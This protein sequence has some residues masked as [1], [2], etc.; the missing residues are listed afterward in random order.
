MGTLQRLSQVKHT[1]TSLSRALHRFSLD[2]SRPSMSFS[3]SSFASSTSPFAIKVS[4]GEDIRRV[5]FPA[6]LTGFD[7]LHAAVVKLFSVQKVT[8]KYVDDE[9]DKITIS[10]DDE[11][12]EALNL[13]SDRKPVLLR[14]FA[15][16]VEE[17]EPPKPVNKVPRRCGK[18]EHLKARI[19]QMKQNLRKEMVQI[20]AHEH[21]LKYTASPYGHG[22]FVCDT[23]DSSG[24]GASYHCDE[25]EFDVHIACVASNNP[26]SQ[27]SIR[28]QW[29]TLQRKALHLL[30]VGTLSALQQ[31]WDLLHKQLALSVNSVY[32]LY[33]L[34]CVESLSGN[35]DSA[36]AF[37]ERAIDDGYND[38][39]HM[40][41]DSDL[42]RLR[43]TPAFKA[44]VARL[45]PKPA[46]LPVPA[47]Q[48]VEPMP[49][50][51][52]QPAP[53]PISPPPAIA[54]VAPKTEE[55]ASTE[56]TIEEPAAG[57]DMSASTVASF[58]A[59]LNTL[60][61]MGFADRRNNI[62]ALLKSK[63][64]VVEAIQSLLENAL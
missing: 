55:P 45:E 51:V 25:C 22:H 35:V 54:A 21:P 24:H 8:L 50:P 6:P 41:R 12:Q 20:D 19:E 32:P 61:D 37:L 28:R 30:Q 5:S 39:E 17:K 48:P 49:V 58:E 16:A 11:L 36:L 31:A 7:E 63:G 56:S 27:A 13:V 42:Y 9:G 47:P 10:T 62:R 1:T 40:K 60:T 14:L 59:K 3:A 2:F 53:A 38:V 46:P 4:L 64:D 18:A 34:A 26:P 43:E 57:V 23:C 29:S 33:N 52:P 44:L 15:T